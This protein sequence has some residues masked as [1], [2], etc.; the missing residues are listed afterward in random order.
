MSDEW[1]RH[2]CLAP[3]KSVWPTQ[4]SFTKEFGMTWRRLLRRNLTGQWRG[5][6]AVFLGVAVAT[7]VMTGAL[8][9]G[10]SLRGSLHDL[11]MRQLGGVDYVLIVQH[12][13]TEGLIHHLGAMHFWL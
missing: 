4:S 2:S 12:F 10:D 6:L 8:L 7:G 1:A 11:N 13:I 3:D 5:N 9:V